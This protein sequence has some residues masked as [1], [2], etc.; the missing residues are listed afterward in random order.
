MTHGVSAGH[1]LGTRAGSRWVIDAHESLGQWAEKAG[2]VTKLTQFSDVYG[3]DNEVR[4][5]ALQSL[6]HYPAFPLW[7]HPHA[8]R[9]QL[10]G[11]VPQPVKAVLLLF[12]ISDQLEAKRREE[13]E[14]IRTQGP[15]KVDPTV[16]WIKQTVRHK[17][18]CISW[19]L[20]HRPFFSVPSFYPSAQ[21]TPLLL[22]PWLLF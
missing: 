9:K 13:D 11:M 15:P 5:P 2:L 10:L 14:K 20:M 6:R 19:T 18:R 16:M 17:T 3:L 7:T 21:S 8:S 1:E 4:T 12:P 22:W